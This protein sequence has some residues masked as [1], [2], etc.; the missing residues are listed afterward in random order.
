MLENVTCLTL[1]N[2]NYIARKRDDDDNDVLNST[3]AV[4]IC[5][6]RQSRQLRHNALK[7][8]SFLHKFSTLEIRQDDVGQ[9]NV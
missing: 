4:Y 7:P 8:N 1:S 2:R 5:R 3:I 9:T 6:R